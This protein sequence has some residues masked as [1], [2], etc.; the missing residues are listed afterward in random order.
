MFSFL[1]QVGVDKTIDNKSNDKDAKSMNKV[2]KFENVRDYPNI[3]EANIADGQK[4]AEHMEN[5]QND[6]TE[7]NIIAEMHL[8]VI[9]DDNDNQGGDDKSVIKKFIIPVHDGE[10]AEKGQ[11]GSSKNYHKIQ[12]FFLVHD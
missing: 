2:V 6:Q 12:L 5:T 11:V 10:K 4:T 9:K 7:K 8:L 3:I 1:V